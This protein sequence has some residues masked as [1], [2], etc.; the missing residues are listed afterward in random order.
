M[1]QDIVNADG[2]FVDATLSQLGYVPKYL[3]A[4]EQ[5]QP[6]Q[7]FPSVSLSHNSKLHE[8]VQRGGPSRGPMTDFNVHRF[9]AVV[10]GDDCRVFNAM[11]AKCELMELHR[12]HGVPQ[13]RKAFA[14]LTPAQLQEKKA[15]LQHLEEECFLSPCRPVNA[16]YTFH[17][18]RV[19][20]VA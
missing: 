12:S 13:L 15:V 6:I 8:C 9:D 11:K 20:D 1:D 18:C 19:E 4:N 17:G 14:K 16:L 5:P 10:R 7:F 3:E 2:M